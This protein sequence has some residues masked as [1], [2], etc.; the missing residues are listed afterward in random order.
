MTLLLAFYSIAMTLDNLKPL[1]LNSINNDSSNFYHCCL[2]CVIVFKIPSILWQCEKIS[3]KKFFALLFRVIFCCIWS[4]KVTNISCVLD[5]ECIE[6]SYFHHKEISS[7]PGMYSNWDI[8][9]KVYASTLV[10][11]KDSSPVW[12][13][14]SSSRLLS[15]FLIDH[16]FWISNKHPEL[17]ISKT[18]PDCLKQMAPAFM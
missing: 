9:I 14:P 18:R 12:P 1:D 5:L 13:L 4:K 16:S 7:S 6:T 15:N 3:F 17:N 8:F 2:F 11:Q 10:T